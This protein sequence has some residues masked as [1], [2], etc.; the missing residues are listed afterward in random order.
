MASFGGSVHLARGEVV[1]AEAGVQ[2]GGSRDLAGLEVGA[3]TQAP[4]GLHG[5]PVSWAESC[6]ARRLTSSATG[7]SGSCAWAA[8]SQRASVAVSS[9]SK[10]P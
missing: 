9:R 7:R 5:G 3:A 6:A 1:Q 10:K 8:V 4:V 2:G